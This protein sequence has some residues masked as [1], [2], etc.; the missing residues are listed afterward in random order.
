MKHSTS[1]NKPKLSSG[2][3]FLRKMKKSNKSAIL[4]PSPSSKSR[5]KRAKKGETDGKYNST[6][7]Q[8]TLTQVWPA[9]ST[10]SPP[11]P[12]NRTISEA[13]PPS[14]SPVPAAFNS[15][16]Y[17]ELSLPKDVD[18]DKVIDVVNHNKVIQDELRS[19]DRICAL[20][21]LPFFSMEEMKSTHP[22]S[23]LGEDPRGWRPV[24]NW[25]T[26]VPPAAD[27]C[28]SCKCTLPNCHDKQFSFYMELRVVNHVDTAVFKRTIGQL[29]ESD[30]EHVIRQAYNKYLRIRLFESRRLL[31]SCHDYCVP[32]CL[33]E[34]QGVC[35][36]MQYFQNRQYF[37]LVESRIDISH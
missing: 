4:T 3:S 20:R 24:F 8:Q 16:A 23:T 17:T 28:P 29:N 2:S 18:F 21:E 22:L 14:S 36:A 12:T 1:N 13:V 6:Q 25:E 11:S 32:K 7:Q 37:F 19:L 33:S 35:R 30:I 34:G 15:H 26:D 27:Y 9:A 31:D 10:S 5:T